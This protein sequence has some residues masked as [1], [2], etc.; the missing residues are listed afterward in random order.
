MAG[1]SMN[2]L[3]ISNLLYRLKKLQTF[4]Q[5]LNARILHLPHESLLKT[6]LPHLLYLPAN[7]GIQILNRGFNPKIFLKV[8]LCLSQP[9]NWR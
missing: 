7:P 3:I 6:A 9:K 4:L 2:P 5:R 1:V 8:A